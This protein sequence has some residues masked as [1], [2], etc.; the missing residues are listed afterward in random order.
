MVFEQLQGV[1][2]HVWG[3]KNVTIII[4]D[5]RFVKKGETERDLIVIL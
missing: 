2:V 1:A 3:A 4:G 5:K